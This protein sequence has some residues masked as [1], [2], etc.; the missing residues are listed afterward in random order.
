MSRILKIIYISAFALFLAPVFLFAE[1]ITVTTY[2]PSPYGIYNELRAKKMAIGDDY[3]DSGSYTWE[4][5]NG[6]G[7]EVDVDT[8]LIVEGNAG[9]G[10][11]IPQTR[12][13]IRRTIS[14][15]YPTAG[16]VYGSLHISPETSAAA[17]NSASITF[18]ACQ[19]VTSAQAGIYVQSSGAYGTKMYFGTTNVY[20][21]GSQVRMMI[22][23]LG[24]V[25]IGTLVPGYTLSVA[26]TIYANGSTITAG[27]TTWSD[28]RLKKD[29]E[30]IDNVIKRLCGIRGVYYSWKDNEFTKNFPKGRQIGII[31]Q[32]MEDVFPELVTTDKNGYKSIAYDKFT[33]VLLEAVKEQE[34]KIFEQQEINKA[35]QMQIVG[36]IFRVEKLE[37]RLGKCIRDLEKKAK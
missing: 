30:P 29:I 20:A 37:K 32:N 8:D 21:T 15:T 19:G 2:Y 17:D 34:R 1:E 23:Q 36:L 22:D 35:Q 12:L 16:Q 5:V 6:D 18:G 33:A 28:I 13:D 10:T 27:S 24:N 31:A 7:G 26:G 25:G 9:I 4:A 14:H 3:I 11:Y